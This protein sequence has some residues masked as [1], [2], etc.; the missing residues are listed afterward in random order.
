MAEEFIKGAKEAGHEIEIADL[1]IANIHPCAGCD[2]CGMN[3]DC[4]LNDDGNVIIDQIL[5]A[6]ALLL[7]FPIHYYN[8]PGSLK[9]LID[10]FY[11][12]TTAI[13]DKHLKVVYITTAWDNDDEVMYPVQVYFDKLFRYM[14]FENVGYVLGKGCGTVS[15]IDDKYYKEAYE[16]GKNI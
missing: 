8:V 5:N 2:R 3:G 14:H 15:M 13:T 4:V 10:R 9:V 6:D 12:R 7:A 16:L 11:S 1:A